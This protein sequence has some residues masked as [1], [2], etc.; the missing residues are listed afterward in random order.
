MTDLVGGQVAFVFA[1]IP[2][3]HPYITSGRL[4]ALGV[5]SLKR[6]AALPDVPTISEGGLRGFNVNAWLG[7]LV[8]A[9]T[10]VNVIDRLHATTVT[11]LQ[12]PEVSE[13][14]VSLGLEPVGSTPAQLGTHLKIEM[15]RW[16]K[17][18]REVKFEV[19]D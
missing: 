1:T 9:G 14:L 10:P 19:V 12:R 5:S 7:L 18:A 16:A 6:N 8:P 15:A 3:A 13:R 11:A 2:T 17:L 4:R